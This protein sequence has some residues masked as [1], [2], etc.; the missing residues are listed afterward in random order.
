[1]VVKHSARAFR[2]VV[3]GVSGSGKSSVG[4]SLARRLKVPFVEGDELHPADNVK[5][6]SAGIPLADEDRSPW[7]SAIG[8]RLST[9]QGGMVVSCSALKVKYRD[10]LRVSADSPIAFLYLHCGRPVLQRR[11]QA[12]KNHFMPSALLDSQ[13]AALEIPSQNERDVLHVFAD[14][15]VKSIVSDTA[16]W[17]NAC[18]KSS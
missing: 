7:L 14:A 13:L 1:M 3:M 11:M 2:V 17:L 5:K 15:T 12:R 4:A 10:Q 16:I 6:M 9:A 18:T 8:T